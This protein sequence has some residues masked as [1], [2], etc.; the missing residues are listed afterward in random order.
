MT[1][2]GCGN[3]YETLDCPTCGYRTEAERRA[4]ANCEHGVEGGCAGN[5]AC[6]YF[7][8]HGRYASSPPVD[9]VGAAE[10]M[11]GGTTKP[12]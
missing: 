6:A 9:A 5:A 3:S 8:A 1:C 12:N 2:T 10:Y 11:S 4:G 7:A